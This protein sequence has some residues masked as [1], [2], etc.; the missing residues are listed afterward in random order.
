ME[1]FFEI[2][3]TFKGKDH[4]FNGRLVTF[5]YVYKFFVI[6]NNAELEFERD[7]ERNYRVLNNDEEKTRHIDAE[8]LGVVVSLLRWSTIRHLKFL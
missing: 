7:E 3:I 4:V 1:H 5:G 6:I 8:L 2:P